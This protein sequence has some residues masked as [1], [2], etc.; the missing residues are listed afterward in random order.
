[1]KLNGPK[2]SFLQSE[3]SFLGRI[4]DHN[5]Y[6]ADPSYIQGIMSIQPPTN[7]KQMEKLIGRFTWVR[8]FITANVGEDVATNC[9]SHV[10]A[11]LHSMNRKDKP[12]SWDKKST[13]CA[14]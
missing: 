6:R 10:M 1:M 3:C 8:E 7:K 14:G 2:C 4:L 9:F 13:K 5:G 12:F 11:V